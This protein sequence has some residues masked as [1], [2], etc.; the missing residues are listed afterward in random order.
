MTSFRRL[1]SL[2]PFWICLLD[3]ASS[4]LIPARGDLESL[5]EMVRSGFYLATIRDQL[6]LLSPTKKARVGEKARKKTCEECMALL[7]KL[8]RLEASSYSLEELELTPLLDHRDIPGRCDYCARVDP[9][10]GR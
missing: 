8:V 4:S 6:P 1:L 7:L 2:I 5:T 10:A 3:L 9:M